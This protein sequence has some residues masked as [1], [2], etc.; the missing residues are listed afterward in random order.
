MGRGATEPG[1]EVLDVARAARSRGTSGKP[2]ERDFLWAQFRSAGYF[3]AGLVVS[4]NST[5]RFQKSYVFDDALGVDDVRAEWLRA[6][7]A[8]L[9]ERAAISAT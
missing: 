1:G 9:C 6:L 3:N 8:R 5:S 7:G 4:G 2:S